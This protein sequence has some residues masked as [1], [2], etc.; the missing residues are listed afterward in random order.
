MHQPEHDL[1]PFQA[2][3]ASPRRFISVGLV[4]LLHVVIIYALATGL[5]ANLVSKLP[6]ELKA[7]V[8]EQKP[9]EQE[10]TPP[11]P[12]PDLAKPPP[13]FVPPPDINIQSEAPATNAISNVQSRRPAPVAIVP[14]KPAG[15]SHSCYSGYPPISKR[16]N[17]QGRVVVQLTVEANG[18][19]SNPKLV[20][21]SGYSR[22]DDAALRC[23]S[24]WHYHPATQAG[25]PIAV[26]TKA[27]IDYRLR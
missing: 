2:S 17:E 19:V 16:L 9:P 1:R 11:P 10:K 12:P 21:S 4:A 3:V 13:P 23:V 27:A 7:E 15:R 22:L 14:P 5:A 24:Y 18:S 6:T 20:K 25:K 26:T 8:V